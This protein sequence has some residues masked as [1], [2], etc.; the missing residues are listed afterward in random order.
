MPFTALL[1]SEWTKIR[2]LRPLLAALCSVLAVTV[3][4]TLLAGAPDGRTAA[5]ATGFD[6]VLFSFTGYAAGQLAAVC[7]GVLAVGAEYRN[8]AVRVSLTAVPDRGR[9]YAA[10]LAVVGALTLVL[11]LVTGFASFLGGQAVLAAGDR[12]GLGEPAVLRAVFGCAACLALVALLAAGVTALLRSTV[13]AFSVLVPLL[14]LAG[15]VL[16]TDNGWVRHLPGTAGLQMMEQT[17][18]GAPGA[19]TGLGVAALWSAAA[20]LAGLAALRSRDA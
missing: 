6:P 8:G 10:K 12:A 11:G 14:V 2:S 4:V 16:G 3:G 17:P 15:P 13:G 7:F 18:S 5:R 19:W 9:F 20:V 1:H